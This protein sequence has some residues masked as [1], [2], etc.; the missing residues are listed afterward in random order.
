MSSTEPPSKTNRGEDLHTKAAQ[1]ALVSKGRVEKVREVDPDEQARQRKKFQMMMGDEDLLEGGVNSPE[2]VPSPFELFASSKTVDASSNPVLGDIAESPAPR[3]SFGDVQDAIVASPSYS[4]PPD[5]SFQAPETEEDDKSTTGALP[6]S[7]RFWDDTDLPPDQPLPPRQYREERKGV[8]EGSPGKKKPDALPGTTIGV[9]PDAAPG[10]KKPDALPGIPIGVKPDALPGK[11]KPDALPGI[12]IGV[13]PEKEEKLSLLGP[14]GKPVDTKSPMTKPSK[15]THVEGKPLKQGLPSPF[16]EVPQARLPQQ[17]EETAPSLRYFA[18]E[19]IEGKKKKPAEKHKAAPQMGPTRE[20]DIVPFRFEEPERGGG[21]Q[22]GREHKIVEIEAAAVP[23]LPA[24]VQPMA[25]AAVSAAT[26]YLSPHTVSLFFQMVG[27]IY[28]M[29]APPG[30]TTTELVLN[31]PSYAN[32]KFY[33]ATITIE[34][35]ATAPDS[36]NI[37]LTGND[38][39]VASFRENIPSLMTAFKNS[40]LPFRVNRIE[41]EYRIERPVFRRKEW[42]EGKKDAGG[43]DLGERRK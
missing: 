32:S 43:G 28:V 19:E 36:F 35:Y 17:Q 18:T 42:G 22:R 37:R 40:D 5:L 21:G 4:P 27:Q 9:K 8:E 29:T 3:S 15:A 41:A 2:G 12:P 6:H 38:A 1:D 14:P 16:E 20:P 25:F 34:K 13:K 7:A 26:P 23:L 24:H 31:S 10:K 33:G 39:A 11:K 30:V